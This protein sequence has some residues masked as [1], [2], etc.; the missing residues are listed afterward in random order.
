MLGESKNYE[1]NHLE[2]MQYIRQ[3]QLRGQLR[4]LKIQISNLFKKMKRK[5]TSHIKVKSSADF[6]QCLNA[7]QCRVNPPPPKKKKEKK[8]NIQISIAET[9]SVMKE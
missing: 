4:F 2:V 6:N 5:I 7:N 8:K 1:L 3:V 9:R